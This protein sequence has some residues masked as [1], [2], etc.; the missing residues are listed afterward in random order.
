MILEITDVLISKYGSIINKKKRNP[1]FPSFIER[2]HRATVTRQLLNKMYKP[3]HRRS[4]GRWFRAEIFNDNSNFPLHCD[5]TFALP[6]SAA[7]PQQKA[8][9]GKKQQRARKKEEEMR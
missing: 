6:P 2:S 8:T 7:V 1:S 3:K 5:A 9:K 4:Q